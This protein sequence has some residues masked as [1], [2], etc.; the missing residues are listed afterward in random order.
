MRIYLAG[1]E[2][3]PGILSWLKYPY[4]LCSYLSLKDKPKQAEYYLSASREGSEWIMDSGLFTFMFG[5]GKGKLKTYDDYKRYAEQYVED[6]LAWGWQHE[7]VECDVQRVLSVDEC[8]RLREEVFE[9]CGLPVMYVWHIPE[10]EDGLR[11]MADR[12]D[13]I[14]VS[15]P[16][17]RE[18]FSQQEN[19][20]G[21]AS[22]HVKAATL[23]AL[24]II[25]SAKK[26][27]RVHLLGN[28]SASLLRMP[29][30]AFS[31]DSTSWLYAA[32]HGK[33]TIIDGDRLPQISIHSLKWKRW[34][35]WCRS[36]HPEVYEIIDNLDDSYSATAK[37][38]AATAVS[39]AISYLMMM[40][41]I[42]GETCE[43]I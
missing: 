27:P 1:E 18:V 31:S 36:L 21:V 14:A 38:N 4:R 42:T 35:E 24:S 29:T 8:F 26:P 7:I 37:A 16:E 10:K 22:N 41:K 25:R 17:F 34:C 6:M 12:Y 15:I 11:A 5:A 23:R 2:P 19:K 28:T 9:K 30:P 39:S 13:R 20:V 40:D 33:G 43:S 3:C 32:S